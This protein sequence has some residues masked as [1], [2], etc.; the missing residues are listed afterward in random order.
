MRRSTRDAELSRLRSRVDL[1]RRLRR[2]LDVAETEQEAIALTTDAITALLDGGDGTV[3]IVVPDATALRL[4]P[5]HA[6]EPSASLIDATTCAG[7]RSGVPVVATSSTEFDACAHLR[8]TDQPVSG[9]CAPLRWWADTVGVVHWTGPEHEPL[10]QPTI[11]G[12]EA[13]AHL[14]AS[15]IVAIRR[16]AAAATPLRI[17]PLT[18]LL[19]PTS[20]HHAILGLVTDLVPFSLAVCTI[21]ELDEYQDT[22][23]H[24]T[25]DRA[26]RLFAHSLT[27]TVRPDDIVGRTDLDRFTV[28]FPS[29]SALDGAHALER[30]RETLVLSLAGTDLPKFTASFGV[31]DSNQGDSIEAIT[32]TAELAA[33]LARQQGAN[34]VVVA[35]DE[36]WG[37]GEPGVGGN[38][39]SGLPPEDL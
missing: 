16:E 5:A 36:T 29:T 7:L 26:L 34:R 37:G 27:T 32:E 18:G 25:G 13:L 17:D 3:R 38:I 8:D 1:E 9:V 21:D 22:H 35:G 24:D 19:N 2:S 10:D 30:V 6:I 33:A 4:G 28:V 14:A 15:K 31:S 39:D 20:V 11:D 12:I 23:G